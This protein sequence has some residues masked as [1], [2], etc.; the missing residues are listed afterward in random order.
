[1]RLFF[2]VT[3]ILFLIF[4]ISA[5]AQVAQRGITPPSFDKS[6]TDQIR[7]ITMPSV[8]VSELLAE[9]AVDRKLG[10]PF[11]FGYPF[12][13]DYSLENSGTW[14]VLPD[15]SRIW[16]LKIESPGAYSI[17]LIYSDFYMPPGAQFFVYDDQKKMVLGAFTSQNN[18]DHGKFSTSPVKGDVCIL[19]YFEPASVRGK[20]RLEIETIVHGYKNIFSFDVAKDA[21]GFGSS[22]S[23]NNNVNCP[24]GEPWQDEKRAVAMILTSGGSR[25]CTGALVNN[26]REDATPYF[27]TANHCLGGE[28]TWIFMFNY[29][30]PDCSN[31]DG[32]TSYT[33]SGST[34]L[35]NYSSSDFALLELSSQPPDY[36]NVYYA[37]WS[38]E[39]IAS[40]TST[41]IH[42]PSGDIKKIS[43]DYDSVTSTN[44]LST[45]GTT[46]WR[47]GN[48]EDGTTEP[49]SSGSPLFDQNHR[50]VGQL[51]GGYA[52]C[53]SITADWY[54]KVARS[55]NGGGSISSQL[56]FWLDMDNTG[57]LTLDG[58]DPNV[59]VS[60]SHTPLENTVDT[61]NNYEVIC[62]ITS[63]FD[64]VTDS[65][66]LHYEIDDY[67]TILPLLPTGTED[68]YGA[69]IPAQDGGTVIDYYISAQNVQGYYDTTAIYT[70]EVLNVPS[71][72]ISPA[73]LDETMLPDDSTYDTLYIGNIGK[74]NLDYS[75]SLDYDLVKLSDPLFQKLVE[76]NRI[77]PAIHSYPAEYSTS[78]EA[79]GTESGIIGSSVDKGAGGPD[80]FG[81]YW[82]DSDEPDGP[83]FDWEDISGYGTDITSGLDDDNYV[84]PYYVGFAFSFYENIYD[85]LYIGS[86]GIVGFDTAAMKARTEQAFPNPLTPNNI[87]AWLWDDLDITNVSN[88]GGAV[89]IDANQN[90]CIIQFDNFPEYNGS[91]GDVVTG[92][93]ILYPDGNIELK[94][95]SIASGFDV[96]SCGVGIENADATD[97]LQVVYD[98][99]Y[100][101][102]SLEILITRPHL[103]L[104]LSKGEGSLSQNT[105]DTII[106]TYSTTDMENGTYNAD[107]IIASND[108]DSPDSL[109]TV[110]VTLTVSGTGPSYICGDVNGDELVNLIDIN[111]M[112]GYL[113]YEGPAPD[114]I[115]SG[116]LN[117]DGNLNLLD[118]SYA[119]AYLYQ[120]GPEPICEN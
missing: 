84:G 93:V 20:G 38:A 108:P 116:D 100:L 97:G 3:A 55:W 31:T 16:R 52:S 41:A 17:N 68:E 34:L 80:N 95:F 115:E 27:L 70:F 104:S 74:G 11:R 75:L 18:K 65:L 117:G 15:G 61:V 111:Y 33:V 120:S 37:G 47:V 99:P 9:D 106:C 89:Y 13:I 22:G 2:S 101:H 109:L 96:T 76:N 24:E 19:E 110:P 8:N 43:F 1:M 10:M 35:S 91:A 90:R 87:I 32:P 62:S 25:I 112:I 42:H 66:L 94:Y 60:I 51:H 105:E 64:L 5:T 73:S 69:E 78:T 44:Y 118:I 72:V 46:H 86:N 102:D 14:T 54:G 81:Y 36:Y 83:S 77:A 56:K 12:D 92:Q 50:I 45:S 26:V 6:L 59:G 71:I 82:I 88:P 119:I 85:S 29:E 21:L 103:W 57:V 113:Y 53:A 79:K 7:T 67:W 40:Q 107:I 114:P 30:S 58:F 63:R 49:G 4:S 28:A 39:D 48:W 23:C 98:A